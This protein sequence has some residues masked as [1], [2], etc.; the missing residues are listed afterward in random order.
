[1]GLLV[2]RCR[3]GQRP[4]GAMKEHA[5][6]R[7]ERGVAPAYDASGIGRFCDDLS[8]YA[9]SGCGR[10]YSFFGRRDRLLAAD[11]LVERDSTCDEGVT[12]AEWLYGRTGLAHGVL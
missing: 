9:A 1:M 11:L 12:C 7:F 5:L 3:L 6:A 2:L 4:T 8:P 10:F